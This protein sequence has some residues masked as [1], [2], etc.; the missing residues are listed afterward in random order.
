[1]N[2]K[3]RKRRGPIPPLEGEDELLSQ[4]R[5]IRF[6]PTM[7]ERIEKRAGP[8]GFAAWVRDAC[9]RLLGGEADS[10]GSDGADNGRDNRDDDTR[11]DPSA[12]PP[13]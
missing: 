11:R 2:D 5:M 8:Q 13:V 6:G 9:R 7:T 1:M 10:C 12:P 4:T 3:P